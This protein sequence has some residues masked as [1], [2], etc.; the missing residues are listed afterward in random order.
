MKQLQNISV[1]SKKC[2][3]ISAFFF[4]HSLLRAQNEEVDVNLTVGE[5]GTDWFAQPWV[6]VVGGAVFIIIIIAL[7][8]GKSES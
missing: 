6:W 1:M 4:F 8:R 7:V 3:A 2:L 5:E